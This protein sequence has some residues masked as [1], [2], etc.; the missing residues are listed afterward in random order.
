MLTKLETYE[1]IHDEIL[2]RVC[3]YEIDVQFFTEKA[4]TF[5]K[6]SPD[7]IRNMSAVK[8]IQGNLY[9]DKLLLR[10]IKKLIEKIKN[11]D[12]KKAD[13]GSEGTD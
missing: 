12:N 4:S 11:A 1:K 9:W 10:V 5:K 7:H 6:K 3:K 2:L 13:G 8:E